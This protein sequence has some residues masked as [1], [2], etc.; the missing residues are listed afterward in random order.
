MLIINNRI[1]R[2]YRKCA[3]SVEEGEAI[4][5]KTL[6]TEH[7][8]LPKELLQDRKEM[9]VLRKD[10]ENCRTDLQKQAEEHKEQ[11]ADACSWMAGGCRDI[12]LR[13]RDSVA[14]PPVEDITLP[15]S[16]NIS[17]PH[18]GHA[19]LP[20]GVRLLGQDVGALRRLL[21]TLEGQLPAQGIHDIGRGDSEDVYRRDG[22]QGRG[23]ARPGPTSLRGD[24]VVPTHQRHHHPANQCSQASSPSVLGSVLGSARDA[25]PG[26]AGISP[27]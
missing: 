4:E 2:C 19:C 5:L 12:I 14:A 15:Q 24:P 13:E 8:E 3:W 22:E 17:S 20:A 27:I 25:R 11:I 9:D 21:A 18:P 7:G 26:H 1:P 6:R 23:H 16:E 10:I